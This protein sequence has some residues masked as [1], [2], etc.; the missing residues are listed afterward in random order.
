MQRA[1][2]Q[3]GRAPGAI[4]SVLKC[5]PPGFLQFRESSFC[6]GWDTPISGFSD[7]YRKQDYSQWL[8]NHKEFCV[9][10][11]TMK[12]SME[13][14]QRAWKKFRELW[15][16]YKTCKMFHAILSLKFFSWKQKL[17]LFVKSVNTRLSDNFKIRGNA[18]LLSKEY[19]VINSQEG[20]F[21]LSKIVSFFIQY[22]VFS[23]RS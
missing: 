17:F 15:A 11:T 13:N 2:V 18:G 4:L 6:F 21:N 22:V 9:P 12:I 1:V 16:I 14:K 19:L 5:L 8:S 3:D 23:Y 7:T 10:I 20:S